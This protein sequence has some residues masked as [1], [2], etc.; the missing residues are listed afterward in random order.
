M[1]IYK[2]IRRHGE[3]CYSFGVAA[4]AAPGYDAEQEALRHGIWFELSLVKYSFY[5]CFYI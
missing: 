3:H 4:G 5:V 2:N 1:S